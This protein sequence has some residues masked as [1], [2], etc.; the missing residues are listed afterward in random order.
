MFSPEMWCCS[1]AYHRLPRIL[2]WETGWRI[3]YITLIS[4]TLKGWSSNPLQNPDGSELKIQMFRNSSKG[5]RLDNARGPAEH[6]SSAQIKCLQSLPSQQQHIQSHPFH[7]STRTPYTFH[8]SPS[9]TLPIFHMP[10]NPK[11]YEHPWVT[12][13]HQGLIRTFW[14]LRSVPF[15]PWTN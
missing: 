10:F 6:V 4:M 3:D 8:H 7:L 11:S 13:L 9:L 12:G 2:P 1:Y 14:A 15:N 5:F